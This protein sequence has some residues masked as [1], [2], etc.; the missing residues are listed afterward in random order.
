[1]E[2]DV[3]DDFTIKIND[4]NQLINNEIQG[5][6]YIGRDLVQYAYILINI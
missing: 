2:V 3:Y 6:I 5:Y 1:M 4:I